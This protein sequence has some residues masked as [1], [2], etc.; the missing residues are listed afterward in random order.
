MTPCEILLYVLRYAKMAKLT[1]ISEA[2]ISLLKDEQNSFASSVFKL[3]FG[4]KN[5][6]VNSAIMLNVV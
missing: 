2:G 3:A 1:L 4:Q 5:Y 6:N